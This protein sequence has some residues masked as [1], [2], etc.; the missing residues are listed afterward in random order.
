[1]AIGLERFRHTEVVEAPLAEARNAYSHQG[2][3]VEAGEL[4][5][6]QIIKVMGL[7][8]TPT[9]RSSRIDMFAIVQR[10]K[11]LAFATAAVAAYVEYINR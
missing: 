3:V 1:M 5:T 9:R 11:P 2:G 7:E 6:E 8:S 10:I 4:S